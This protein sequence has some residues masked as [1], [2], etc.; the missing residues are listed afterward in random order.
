MSMHGI[1]E[2]IRHVQKATKEARAHGHGNNIVAISF[3]FSSAFFSMHGA[4]AS[5]RIWGTSL[6]NEQGERRFHSFEVAPQGCSPS[7]EG[8][9]RPMSCLTKHLK[10]R[11]NLDISIYC[12]DGIFFLPAK[13]IAHLL[14]SINTGSVLC[15]WSS[16]S[17]PRRSGSIDF[18]SCLFRARVQRKAKLPST[19]MQLIN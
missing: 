15:M 8:W 2:A 13:W 17:A 3:D 6:T 16:R 14:N 1:R 18:P 5:K 11:L 12:D 9:S 4:V 10:E 7:P 19:G